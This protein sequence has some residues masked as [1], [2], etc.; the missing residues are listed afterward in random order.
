MAKKPINFK[1]QLRIT[2]WLDAALK[3]EK[4]K[5][6]K[7]PVTRDFVPG[8]EAAQGWGY[9]VAG[10][11]LLEQSLKGLL[12][13]RGKQVPQ[14]HSLSTL[15][16]KCDQNDKA[17]VREYYV[18]YRATIGGTT[19]QYPFEDLDSFLA[20]LDG[21]QDRHGNH[22]G[23]FDWRYFLIEENHSET[24]PL[25][26]VDYMHEVVYGCTCIIECALVNHGDPLKFT[27]SLRLRQ[28]RKRKYSDWLMVRT[29]SDGWDQ[30]G[31]R[32]EVLWGP[33]YRERYDLIEFKDTRNKAYFAEIPEDAAMPVVDKRTEIENFDA[34]EGLR[35]IGIT[36]IRRRSDAPVA[37]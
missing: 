2:A 11:F 25:V 28:E 24:M 14:I 22:R 31:D 33:D 3:K 17:V 30:L 9:V 7:C 8:Q 34:E 10:Y 27:R 37:G 4:E 18:D 35:S 12:Y 36:R 5:Y 32:L 26:S 19:G 29:N 23:S 13:V 20:N 21:D 1:D 15:F 6:K 16:G